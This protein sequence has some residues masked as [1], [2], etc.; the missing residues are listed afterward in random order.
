[1]RD[2]ERV[3]QRGA[4]GCIQ[5]APKDRFT[6]TGTVDYGKG[7]R[8]PG[9]FGIRLSPRPHEAVFLHTRV[10]GNVPGRLGA[11]M[12][13]TGYA[14]APPPAVEGPTVVAAL[15][16]AIV[17]DPTEGERV[18]AVATPVEERV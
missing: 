11:S 15:K 5:V 17:G 6:G 14:Q 7:E 10:R 13:E 1:M 2:V 8:W 4:Q 9:R 12:A 3:L 18:V 16:Q